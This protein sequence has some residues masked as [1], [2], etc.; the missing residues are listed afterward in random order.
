MKAVL[1]PEPG[2]PENLFIG[3]WP[4][5]KPAEREIL[6]R[7]AAAALNRADLLQ[8]AGNYPPPPGESPIIGLEMAGT[9][10]SVGPG[11]GR[12]RPG[13]RVCG[14]LGGGGYAQY[15]VLH[16][17]MAIPVPQRLSLE[18]AAALPEVF[19]TAFQA[20]HWL[21]H[22]Q[23]GESVLIHAGAS[24]VGTAAIQLCKLSQATC[25]VTASPEKHALCLQLGAASAIDYML[26]DF[27]ALTRIFTSGKGADVVLDFIGAPYFSQNLKALA[28]D[29]RLVIL[30][31]MGGAKTDKVDL[32]L[33]LR[34]RL[35]IIGTTLR[36]RSL[37]YKIRLTREFLGQFHQHLESGALHP[38]IDSVFDWQDVVRA[39]Q[40][41]ESNRN[42]GKIVLRVAS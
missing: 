3:E 19:L 41:M 42:R 36:T 1:L 11:V 34:K 13:D 2:P 38:V 40:Y 17:E 4:D 31:S 28:T 22:I 6:V 26:E 30:A 7:V 21:A 10:E 33:I 15:A 20:L 32:G 27:A 16:E 14:L 18:E 5:P 24:G 9:V 25:I 37:D 12:W 29:G 8:R 35:H 23:P 39:H